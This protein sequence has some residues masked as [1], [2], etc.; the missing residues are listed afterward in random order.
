M[1]SSV[2]PVP[3]SGCLRISQIGIAATAS[4]A[5]SWTGPRPPRTC[6]SAQYRA[7]RRISASLASSEGWTSNTPSEIHRRAP[8]PTRP[9]NI[10]PINSTTTA[11]YPAHAYR[12]RV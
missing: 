5:R 4:G 8:M 9:T 2:S 11:A 6:F 12:A 10:T 7:R 1:A 3:R